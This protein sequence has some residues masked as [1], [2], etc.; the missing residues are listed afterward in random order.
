MEIHVENIAP[1]WNLWMCLHCNLE[2]SSQHRQIDTCQR[3][4]SQHIKTCSIAG[5]AW[6]T[7][8]AGHLNTAGSSGY[9]LGQLAQSTTCATPA[10]LLFSISFV[11]QSQHVS[12]YLEQGA[13]SQLQCRHILC[14][15]YLFPCHLYF[16][17]F[18]S[19]FLITML[20]KTSLSAF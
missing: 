11:T 10:T 15:F 9:V 7:A 18:V 12:I 3:C 6:A 13:W 20:H 4:L 8:W 19:L 14:L 2:H 17:L 1:D 16:H 5:I